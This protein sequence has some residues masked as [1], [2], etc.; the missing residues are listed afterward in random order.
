MMIDSL[1]RYLPKAFF[2][3]IKKIIKDQKAG[4]QALGFQ[5]REENGILTEQG[6][7]ADHIARLYDSPFRLSYNSN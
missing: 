6:T 1:R 7:I 3:A 2:D 4:L 5:A